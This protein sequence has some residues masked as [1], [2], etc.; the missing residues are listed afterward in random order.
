MRALAASFLLV[1]A[2]LRLGLP[3]ETRDLNVLPRPGE[4][5]LGPD[6]FLGFLAVLRLRGRSRLLGIYDRPFLVLG[7]PA[8]GDQP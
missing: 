1:V 5:L 7:L 8:L 2:T 4:G 6:E 3:L